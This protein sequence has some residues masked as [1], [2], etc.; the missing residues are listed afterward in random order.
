MKFVFL[1][2][3]FLLGIFPLFTKNLKQ[4]LIV[5]I[6]FA[7]SVILLIYD[8][9]NEISAPDFDDSAGAALVSVIP[10]AYVAVFFLSALVKL[11]VWKIKKSQD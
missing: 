9:H 10:I 3:L 7:A 8:I 6:I 4:F 11:I 1:I 5:T 2:I